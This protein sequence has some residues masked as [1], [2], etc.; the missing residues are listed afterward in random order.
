MAGGK[1]LLW[2]VLLV[3][4]GKN[5]Q[6]VE[7]RI[8]HPVLWRRGARGPWEAKVFPFRNVCAHTRGLAGNGAK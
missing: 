3:V 2:P 7:G 1:G 5:A 4:L 6:K 8:A